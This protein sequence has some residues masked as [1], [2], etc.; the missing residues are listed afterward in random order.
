MGSGKSTI[1]KLVAQKLDRAFVDTDEYLVEHYGP[2]SEILNQPNGDEKFA[3]IEEK[4]ASTLSKLNNLV[5][6][7]GGRFMLRQ[8][9]IDLMTTNGTVVCLEADLNDIVQR[10]LNA[11]C[12]TYRPKFEKAE[13]KLAL[14]ERLA[15]QSAPYFDMFLKVQTSGRELS[16]I[17]REIVSSLNQT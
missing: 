13:N 12:D 10:L 15:E 9:N 8:A 5:I 4:V 17:T 2:A 14:M 6:S 11:T 1:G 3:L 16:D 7:T